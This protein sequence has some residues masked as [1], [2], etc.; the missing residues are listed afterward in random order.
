MDCII[1]Q[2]YVI[3][4]PQ[5]LKYVKNISYVLLDKI[6]EKK[7]TNLQYIPDEHKTY[8]LIKKSIKNDTSCTVIKYVKEQNEELHYL[9]LKNFKNIKYR[10]SSTL[11]LN[12]INPSYDICKL[13]IEINPRVSLFTHIYKNYIELRLYGLNF[14]INLIH[15]LNYI[16]DD[17][18]NFVVDKDC[19]YK[20]FFKDTSIDD[21]ESIA[22]N[23][24]K[25]FFQ[26]VLNHSNDKIII[27]ASKIN[28]IY[29]WNNG[30][31]FSL[32]TINEIIKC[33][34]N[35]KH[36]LDNFFKYISVNKSSNEIIY[37]ENNEY[38]FNNCFV[39][40]RSDNIELY[41]ILLEEYKEY[42]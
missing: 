42:Y 7:S 25:W 24:I 35:I 41:K 39:V 33:Y 37:N 4:K 31:N 8:D 34:P 36:Y 15:D 32:N 40:W 18:K 2:Q 20:I 10:F 6:I 1:D 3:D 9:F 14:D 22:R 11:F 13:A 17:E 29:F 16:T 21:I 5:C 26:C 30:Y 12:L 27:V 23:N 19:R 38:N 28:I